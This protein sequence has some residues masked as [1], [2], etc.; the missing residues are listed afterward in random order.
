MAKIGSD[1]DGFGQWDTKDRFS[2]T[3]NRCSAGR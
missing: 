1:V 3:I 2:G